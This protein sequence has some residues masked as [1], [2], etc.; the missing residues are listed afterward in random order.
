M[1]PVVE[2]TLRA[3]GEPKTI[4]GDQLEFPWEA[5]AVFP[6]L[7]GALQMRFET[8]HEAVD[9]LNSCIFMTLLL[10]KVR[11]QESVAESGRRSAL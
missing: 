1:T 4:L 5:I 6:S 9:T 2:S 8:S 11:T 3:P 10:S 7:I